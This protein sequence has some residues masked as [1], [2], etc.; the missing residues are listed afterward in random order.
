MPGF[1]PGGL[2]PDSTQFT[3]A[4]RLGQAESAIRDFC[5]WHIAPQITEGVTVK[6]S[7][8]VTHV[9]RTRKLV[10]VTNV[11]L[12][13]SSLVEGVNF[14]VDPIGIL[15]RIDGGQFT[16]WL[17]LT[18]T[19]GYD[20]VPPVLEALIADMAKSGAMGAVGASKMDAGPFSVTLS[21]TADAGGVGLST[22]QRHVLSRYALEPGLF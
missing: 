14:T 16:G 1:T 17:S 3:E 2:A 11:S 4:D 22:G 15:E 18:M 5:R 12:N 19:H 13:G 8:Y 21:H 10:T 7:G 20:T 6:G 9:L